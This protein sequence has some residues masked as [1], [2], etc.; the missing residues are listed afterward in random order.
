M[1]SSTIT[2][3]VLPDGRGAELIVLRAGELSLSICSFGATLTSLTV[4]SRNLGVDDVLLGCPDM[5]GYADNRYFFGVTVGRFANRIAG[6]E[7]SLDGEEYHISENK[8]GCSL[9]GGVEGFSKRLWNAEIF[10]ENGTVFARLGLDSPDGDQGYPGNLKA[11]VCYGLTEDNR[12]VCRYEAKVDRTCPVNLTNHSYFNLAG[13]SSGRNVLTTE[14]RLCCSGYVEVDDRLLPTGEVK[15]VESTPLDF[16]AVKTMGKDIAPLLN[17]Q[18]GGYDHCMVVDGDC[19]TLRPFG[20]FRD[21]LTGRRLTGYMTQPGL[22]FYTG[23][24]LKPMPG[25]YGASYNKHSGFCI[26]PEFFPDTPNQKAFPSA[27]FGPDRDFCE[28][29]VFA[30]DW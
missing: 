17:S 21:P 22:Q 1:T 4:P 23:N 9:H 3:A 8:P 19:G 28:S 5:D 27:L 7:F 16:R 6:A 24:M 15:S 30:F 13:H 12:L 25:K 18:L 10:T 20:E 2:P 29:A 11:A 14:T 26:E